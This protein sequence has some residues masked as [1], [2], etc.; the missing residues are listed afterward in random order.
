[1]I[2]IL[3]AIYRANPL[4]PHCGGGHHVALCR[5]IVPGSKVLSCV[6]DKDGVFPGPSKNDFPF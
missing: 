2:R 4:R 5:L 1:M 3:C 6:G